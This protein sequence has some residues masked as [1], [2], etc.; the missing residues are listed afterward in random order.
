MLLVLVVRAG[1][2]E[3]E[4]E[5]H[6]SLLS[7]VE[8]R[9]ERVLPLAPRVTVGRLPAEAGAAHV[10]VSLR[11]PA[12]TQRVS[13]RHIALILR[14]DGYALEVLSRAPTTL[15]GEPLEPGATVRVGAGDEIG[16]SRVVTLQLRPHGRRIDR[17]QTML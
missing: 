4:P 8:T 11:D 2:D 17:D 5:V 16:L 1:V 9:S 6:P 10:A 14:P 13:R 7:V 15:N 3:W 12:A